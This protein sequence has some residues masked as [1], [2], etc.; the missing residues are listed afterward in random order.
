MFH[1]FFK[2]PSYPTEKEGF[3]RVDTV[4]LSVKLPS[5]GD[6]AHYAR[7]LYHMYLK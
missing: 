2:D 1:K 4:P 5:E 3:Y 6:M 7:Q